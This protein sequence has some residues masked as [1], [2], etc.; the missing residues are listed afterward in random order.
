MVMAVL[1]HGEA[2][3]LMWTAVVA[4]LQLECELVKGQ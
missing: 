4:M 2:L 1:L 3:S